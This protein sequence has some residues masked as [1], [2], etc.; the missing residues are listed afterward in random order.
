MGKNIVPK[1][2]TKTFSGFKTR[3]KKVL[4]PKKRTKTFSGFKTRWVSKRDGKKVLVP[5]KMN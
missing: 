2:R 1:K 3:W 5:K 4:V